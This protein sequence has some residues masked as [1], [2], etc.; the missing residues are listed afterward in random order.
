MN[1]SKRKLDKFP[2]AGKRVLVTGCGYKEVKKVFKDKNSKSETHD[3]IA[4]DGVEY[5]VNI[6]AATAYQ[7]AMNGATV[8]I[9]SK[10]IDKLQ[11]L[12]EVITDSLEEECPGNI[13]YTAVDLFSHDDAFEFVKKIETNLPLYWVQCVGLGAESFKLENDN[14]YL[15]LDCLPEE[16]MRAEYEVTI[17]THRLLKFLLPKF[18]IQNE[19]KIVI[20]T[21]MSG[22]RFYPY[23]GAH[24]SGKAAL[25]SYAKVSDLELSPNDIFVT[26]LRPGM[27]DTGLYD[28]DEVIKANIDITSWFGL[29]KTSEDFQLIPPS[30]VAEVICQSLIAKA[31]IASVNILARG[32]E[33]FEAS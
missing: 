16:L 33:K 1:I 8:H 23:G 11:H 21:S 24:C 10:S 20:V 4:I 12:S 28:N 31:H 15:K 26:R 30:T 3:S 5:K 14:P 9:V 29:H 18:R 32:Q 7:L 22:V 27:V 13:E 19:T 17:S 6:G 2:L 25:D